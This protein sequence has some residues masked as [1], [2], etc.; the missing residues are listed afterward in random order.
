VQRRDCWVGEREFNIEKGEIF[1][2][3]YYPEVVV[4][5]IMES[6]MIDMNCNWVNQKQPRGLEWIKRGDFNREKERKSLLCD[7]SGRLISACKFYYMIV[8]YEA[9]FH[10]CIILARSHSHQTKVE[11]QTDRRKS[12]VFKYYCY[13]LIF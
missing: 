11:V 12:I 7:W 4:T 13:L 10:N 9:T 6:C 2:L 3:N 5:C 8:F 1:L